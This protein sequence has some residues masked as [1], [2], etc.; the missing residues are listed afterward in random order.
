[1]PKNPVTL[2]LAGILVLILPSV[3]LAAPSVFDLSWWTVDGAPSAPAATTP[4]AAQS[5]NRMPV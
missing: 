5:A 4:W 3:V 2:I 1:M